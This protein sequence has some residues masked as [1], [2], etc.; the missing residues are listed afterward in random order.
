MRKL[1]LFLVPLLAFSLLL[2]NCTKE[3]VYSCN[4]KVDAWVKENK[5]AVEQMSRS[6]I[7]EKSDDFQ[8]AIYAASSS[9]KKYDLWFAKLNEVQRMDWNEQELKHIA[10][11]KSYLSVELFKSKDKLEEMK[12]S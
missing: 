6:Q 12:P 5:T 11:L 3:A 2:T 4:E 9:N 7:L 1:A 10:L 8:K